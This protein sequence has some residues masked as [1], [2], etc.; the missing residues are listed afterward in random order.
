MIPDLVIDEA[1]IVAVSATRDDWLAEP[2][3]E[4]EA[5]VHG[6]VLRRRRE[7]AAGRSCARRALAQLGV[8]AQ[9]ILAGS[10]REPVWATEFLGS[11]THCAGY[12]GAAVARAASLVGLGID[13][14]AKRALTPRARAMVARSSELPVEAATHGVDPALVVFSAKESF[15]K[16]WFPASR[17]KLGFLDVELDFD[18][19]TGTFVVGG[20][21][22]WWPH[23][24][25]PRFTGRFAS[26]GSHVFAVTVG[27]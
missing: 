9:P 6:A 16:A 5:I 24:Q 21:D 13:A 4:E 14:E 7:F 3:P 18:W 23:P 17:R 1:D 25:R 26:S 27:R 22:R 2:L 8:R 19:A 15:Y 11:I 10:R 20:I 12:C